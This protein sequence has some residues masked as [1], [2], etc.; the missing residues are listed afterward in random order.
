MNY[1]LAENLT[2][3][4][5]EKLLFEDINLCINQGDK[6]ALIARNGAGK[7]TLLNILAGK[8]IQDGG[9]ITFHKEIN[10]RFLDQTPEFQ[11]N[12]DIKQALFDDD[13]KFIRS[14]NSYHSALKAMEKDESKQNQ[15]TLNDASAQMDAIGAW[16]YENRVKEILQRLKIN[17]LTQNISLLSGGQK[18]KIALARVLIDEADF[19]VLDEP[20]NH[21]DLEMIEWLEKHLSHSKTTLLMVTHDRYF[22]DSICNTIIELDN[23]QLTIYRGTYGEYLIKKSEAEESMRQGIEKAKNLYRT[24]LD[25]MRRMP[26]ARA[27]KSKARINAFYDIEKKAKKRIKNDNISFSVKAKRM[28]KKIL[29]LENISKRYDDLVLIEDFS[30]LFKRGDRIGVV[31]KN[32]CGKSTLMNMITS[33]IEPDSGTIS[34]GETVHYGYFKQD[35]YINEK[36]RRVI[37]IVK[38][39]A[40]NIE[41]AN[42]EISAGSFLQQF[43]FNPSA[44]HAWFSTLSGGEKRKLY[45]LTVLIQNPNFLILDEPTNDLD[46]QTMNALE[47]F[48]T[49]FQGCIL[50]ISHDRWFLDK[51]AEHL[52]AFE[53]DGKI[54]N[55]PGNYTQ[56][57]EN[58]QQ[59]AKQKAAQTPTITKQKPKSTKIS[60]KYIREFEILSKEIESLEEKKATLE[61]QLNQGETDSEKLV[62]WSK[63]HAEISEE[64]D[65]KSFRWLELSEM[66]EG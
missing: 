8:D 15:K 27:T 7:T 49:N 36:D 32:G 50:L 2:K 35:G 45:L 5:G 53:G 34:T 16:D 56:Y 9:K 46:I 21:L 4:F 20:T 11:N 37:D 62:I 3:S 30:Y 41:T 51:M 14:I 64:L 63:E 12:L 47:T 18:K 22:L 38:D 31:G 24:E 55:F 66:I 29:E 40:E 1:L 54:R 65:E 44:Q 39:V 23:F 52:F 19:L 60:N 13:N 33:K 58:V 10:V 26:Q 6:I 59:K 25:W 28:G 17:D 61:K 48:L 57:L 43:G 42:G